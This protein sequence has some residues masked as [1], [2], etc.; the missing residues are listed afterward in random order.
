[1]SVVPIGPAV[2]NSSDGES[3]W[4]VG[5]RIRIII[6][7]E[8]TNQSFSL[9]ET[10]V[11]PGGGPPPHRH[12]RESESYYILEGTLSVTIDGQTLA[13]GPGSFV[14]VPPAAVHTFRNEQ[15][16]QARMLVFVTPAGFENYFRVVGTP[17]N[18]ADAAPP[19]VTP[20]LIAALQRFAPEHH[21]EFLL[22]SDA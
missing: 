20:D 3:F 2:V 16:S 5:D 7:G 10:L 14:H 6:G 15:D 8:Q 17:V 13:A 12:L 18:A 9:L 19:P 4:M 11:F 22:P 21:L 1:M